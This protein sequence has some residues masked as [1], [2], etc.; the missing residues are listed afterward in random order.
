MKEAEA[1]LTTI[2]KTV[3]SMDI[4][5]WAAAR[6]ISKAS[7]RVIYLIVGQGKAS[8]E[9]HVYKSIE[10]ITQVLQHSYI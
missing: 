9:G 7:C 6:A 5:R 10:E 8:A 2:R 3:A 4:D 1:F